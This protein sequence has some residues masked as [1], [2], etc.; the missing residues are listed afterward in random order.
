MVLKTTCLFHQALT[1][2]NKANS[3]CPAREHLFVEMLVQ[4]R[5]KGGVGI[6]WPGADWRWR[7]EETA[8]ERATGRPPDG[9]RRA[10]KGDRIFFYSLVQW[11]RFWRVI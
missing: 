1:I 9:P 6:N 2:T 11:G 3:S 7:A 10:F 5:S 4:I 8:G